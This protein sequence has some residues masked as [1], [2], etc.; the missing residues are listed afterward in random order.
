MGGL[1]QPEWSPC[2]STKYKHVSDGSL[3]RYKFKS[4]NSPVDP[5]EL[6]LFIEAGDVFLEEFEVACCVEVLCGHGGEERG[7]RAPLEVDP[8]PVGDEAVL[9]D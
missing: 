1:N 2:T 4:R 9:V 6:K 5:P 3:C 7:L 8:V